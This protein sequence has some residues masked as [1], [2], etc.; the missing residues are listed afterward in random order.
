MN[1]INLGNLSEAVN[2]YLEEKHKTI[3]DSAA[4]QSEVYNKD[5]DLYRPYASYHEDHG[6]DG[7]DYRSYR[8]DYKCPKCYKPIHEN[9]IACDK[10]R[11]FFDWSK[12]AHVRTVTE[13]YWE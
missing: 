2:D 7:R 10:C 4:Y 5:K 6:E 1:T 13:L 12:K 9:Q 3:T 8:I 11:I